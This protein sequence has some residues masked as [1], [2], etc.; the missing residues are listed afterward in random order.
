MDDQVLTA[1]GTKRIEY[2]DALRGFTMFLVVFMHVGDW[3]FDAPDGSFHSIMGLVRMPMFFLISGFVLYKAGVVWNTQHIVKFF[4]K[5]IPVQL[6]SPFIFYAVYLHVNHIGL[7]D[8]IFDG[9]K[10][11]YWFTFVLFEYFVFYAIVRFLVRS[12]WGDVILVIMGICMYPF[13]WPVIK[14]ALPI[15]NEI[16]DFFSFQHWHYFIF[17]V[18]GTLTKKYFD[19]VQRWLDG[20]WLLPC[21]ILFFFLEIPF[22]DVLHING[23][24]MGAPVT[25]AGLVILFSFFRKKQRLFSH[26]TRLGRV[27]QYVG[28]R[29]LDIYLIHFFL[30]PVNL[31]DVVTVFHEHPMPIIEGTVSCVIALLIIAMSL[32]IGNVIRLSPFLA[33]WVFGAKNA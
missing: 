20:K 32:L 8:G 3:C 27:F 17:F 33:H 19:A 22:F 26:E 2:I 6:I 13:S 5:K 25:L 31:L 24:I 15:S 18:L 10:H 4:K 14:D 16:L 23:N 12:W 30:V 29:T 9:P 21:C 28:R 11:G 7:M 1:P